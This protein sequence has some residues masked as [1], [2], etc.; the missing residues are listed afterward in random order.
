MSSP[1]YIAVDLGAGSGRVFLAGCDPGEF[2]LEE[3]H[4]FRYPPYS[5]GRFL[6]WNFRLI[7]YEIT[8]GLR[9]AATRSVK[10]GRR[11]WSIG[12]DSWGVD[13]GLVDA[14]G[15]LVA[16]PVCYRDGRTDEAMKRV[17]A[18]VPRDEILDKTGIQ[19]Q[20]FNTLYQLYSEG[21]EV[22]KASTLLLL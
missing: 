5:D 20:K 2:L 4:R 22:K 15:R 11:I 3:V 19:F 7:F 8:T 18:V 13:Y 12:V 10:L 21:G 14:D 17:F 6:R 16:D 1:L 9:L